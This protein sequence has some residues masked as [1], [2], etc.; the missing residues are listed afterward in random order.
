[1]YKIN[2][3]IELLR[4]D[5]RYDEAIAQGEVTDSNMIS[6]TSIMAH[7]SRTVDRKEFE[8]MDVYIRIVGVLEYYQ[9]ALFYVLALPNKNV[10]YI[11]TEEQ[12]GEFINLETNRSET[13]ENQQELQEIEIGLYHDYIYDKNNREIVT[14]SH[15]LQEI[16]LFN[17]LAVFDPEQIGIETGTY[18]YHYSK[19]VSTFGQFVNALLKLI[20]IIANPFTSIGDKKQ[21]VEIE[22]NKKGTIYLV[23]SIGFDS[24]GN[25][26]LYYYYSSSGKKLFYKM[27]EQ[28]I[29]MTLKFNAQ[30]PFLSFLNEAIFTQ[31][32][33]EYLGEPYQERRADLIDDFHEMIIKP[34][35]N[36]LRNNHVFTYYDAMTTLYYLTDDI[37]MTLSSDS[38]WSIFEYAVSRDSLT[39]KLSLEEESIFI[40]LLEAISNN[41][42]A[43]I[44]FLNRLLQKKD[45]EMTYLQFLFERLQGENGLAF[46]NLVNKI[47]KTS[48]FA[49]PYSDKNEEFKYT[50]GPIFLPYESEKY[51]GFYFSNAKITFNKENNINV[52]FDTDKK[53]QKTVKSSDEFGVEYDETVEKSIIAHY[54][55]H[56]FYPIFLDNIEKQETEIKLDTII[57]AFMLLANGDQQFWHNVIKTG[58]YALDAITTLS[59]VGNIA[60]F[61]HLAKLAEIAAVAS[62]V[63]NANKIIRTAN[64]LR[65]VKGAAGVVE[66][67]SGSVNAMLKLTGLDDTESGRS[68]SKVLFFLEL[69]TLTG[70][71][72]VSLNGGLKKVAKEAIDN[73]DGALRAKH[74]ELFADLYKIAGLK[75]IYHH[76]DDF[77][78]LRPKYH[79]LALVNKLWKERIINKMLF[80]TNLRK[81]Y[82]KYLKEFPGLQKG[83]NQAE[84]KTTIFNQR[85][86][87]DEVVEFSLSGDKS[88]LTKYFGNPPD[89]PENTIEILNDYDNFEV[90][91]KG[92]RDFSDLPRNYDSEIKYIFN[93][94]K[95]HINKGDEFV[96]ETQ[97]IFK[98]CGSCRREFVMLEDYLKLQRKKV[99]F[100][101]FSDETVEGTAHLKKKLK[102]K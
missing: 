56:P 53:E 47:W 21:N 76:I 94:L 45:P 27:N 58:E 11:K 39:N 92:A 59:G 37:V 98:T 64:V 10:F 15:N 60:K 42:K 90:F 5:R 100:V 32:N 70:E 23:P 78:Q 6:L 35:E 2:E 25:Y 99:K 40:K 9:P 62:D 88:K 28:D 89:L 46:C 73:S 1:M 86:K 95:N 79:D 7:E 102:I 31:K 77:M 36:K 101:V 30:E 85:K 87:V 54:T 52:D 63:S 4:L 38:L 66:I 44:S 48:R 16:P 49:N 68:L 8:N 13:V 67:T 29:A 12:N 84:F 17:D 34:L 61:R 14:V 71:L 82:T 55:Y 41:E 74:P 19:A 50:D 65:Y 18:T 20:E 97:N 80:T 22:V 57:P 91:V 26:Y 33:F 81:L 93:F 75:K 83:F 51:L 96:I 3:L 43:K 24:S 69:I 72:T